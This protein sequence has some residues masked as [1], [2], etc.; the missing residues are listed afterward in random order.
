MKLSGICELGSAILGNV[1]GPKAGIY[2][3]LAALLWL[4][5][6]ATASS[7]REAPLISQ[8][9]LADNTDVYAFRVP[10]DRICLVSNFIPLQF[11]QSGPNFWKFDD[12]VLYEIKIDNTGDAIP[13]LTYQF[14]FTTTVGNGGTFLYNTGVIDNLT[15]PDW[16]VKQTYTLTLVRPG[17]SPTVLGTNLPCP[18]VNVGPRSTPNYANLANAAINTLPAHGSAKVF[19]G[20]REEPFFADLGSIFDLLGLR[21]TNNPG[22]S[23]VDGLAGANVHSL[24]LEVPINILSA[25]GNNTGIIGVWSTASRPSVQI[26]RDRP[27]RFSIDRGSFVQVSRLGCPLVN[28]VVIPL[29]LKDAFSGLSPKDD[30]VAAPFVLDPQLAHLLQAV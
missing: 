13:D 10:G 26:L 1:R 14:R 25:A 9:P 29:K 11:P 22:S 21:P 16:N 12:N 18:P 19:C 28:E 4:P 17:Q 24:I 3:A 5:S 30:A 20:Q 2:L 15:D 23:G 8:D 7:H 6:T 27:P